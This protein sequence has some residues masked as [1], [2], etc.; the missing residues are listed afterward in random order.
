MILSMC[1]YPPFHSPT[2]LPEGSLG[3]GSA[4]D[5]VGVFGSRRKEAVTWLYAVM[6]NRSYTGQLDFQHSALRT[7]TL[8]GCI[9]AEFIELD[10]LERFRRNA[11]GL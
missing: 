6:V 3:L 11:N 10:E 9:V 2:H 4:R 8:R 7:C 5:T 1:Q